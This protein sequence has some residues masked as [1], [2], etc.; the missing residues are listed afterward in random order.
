MKRFDLGPVPLVAILR[1]VRPDEVVDVA[2]PLVELGFGAVEVPLNSPDPFE[3]IRRLV[4]CYDHVLLGA[5]T[6]TTPDE[7]AG[8]AD[9]G[10]R[11]VVAPNTDVAVVRA[12]KDRGMVCL[13]GFLTPTEAFAAAAAG[14]DGL[15]LFPASASSPAL[16]KGLAAVLDLPVVPVGGVGAANLGPWWAAGVAGFGLGGA[17]YRARDT[18]AAVRAKA[19]AVVRA[20]RELPPR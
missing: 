2:A 8:V 10:G 1:G 20:F 12:A 9:A 19:E 3:S 17:V 15:K 4:G 13:P 16:V 6:V 14:A 5:G 18:P 7:V 11:L